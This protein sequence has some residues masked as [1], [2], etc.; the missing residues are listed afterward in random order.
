[1]N[2]EAAHGELVKYLQ[3]VSSNRWLMLKVFGVLIFFFLFF[4]IF[5]A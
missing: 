2:V 5:M 4:V 3:N 1:M